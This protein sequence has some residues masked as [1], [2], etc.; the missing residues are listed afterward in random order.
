LLSLLRFVALHLGSPALQ[1]KNI[2]SSTR[3]ESVTLDARRGGV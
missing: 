2:N 3:T 1:R